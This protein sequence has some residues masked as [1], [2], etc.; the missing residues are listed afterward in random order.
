MT[1]TTF[2]LKAKSRLR[3]TA[4]RAASGLL[5]FY[6]VRESIHASAGNSLGATH[7][8]QRQAH[9]PY[10]KQTRFDCPYSA[11]RLQGCVRGGGVHSSV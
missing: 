5:G 6:T 4:L 2:R 11:I 3:S 1:H 7:P 8:L 10:V 9:S